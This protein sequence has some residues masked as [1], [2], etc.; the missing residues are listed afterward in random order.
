MGASSSGLR[1]L[2]SSAVFLRLW[3]IGGCVNT[4][5]WFEVLAAALFTLDMT[6]AGFA[7]AV[8]SAAGPLPVFVRGALSGVVSEAVNRKHVLLAGQVITGLASAAVAA[9][10]WSGLAQP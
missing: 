1:A 6:G 2:L 7:V 9:L 5:R 3:S 10:A 8:V 4:M